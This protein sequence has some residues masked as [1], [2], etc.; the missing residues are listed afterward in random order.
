MVKRLAVL[1]VALGMAGQA[2]AGPFED[3]VAA[4]N[5]GDFAT[6]MTLLKP[7]ADQ[8]HVGAQYKL[9]VMYAYGRG[10]PQDDI[11]AVAFYRKAAEQGDTD[12]Q[13]SLGV[14]YE[15]GRGV[16]QD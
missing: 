3:G 16:P 11:L 2:I 1:L 5:I 4:Y 12:G 15:Y 14:T 8:G 10:V 6:A 9:G 7:L 13:F